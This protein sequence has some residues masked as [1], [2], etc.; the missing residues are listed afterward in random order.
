[1]IMWWFAIQLLLLL[2]AHSVIVKAQEEVDEIGIVAVARNDPICAKLNQKYYDCSCDVTCENYFKP[3]P[4][5]ADCHSGCFCNENFALSA[6]ICIR[7]EHCPEFNKQCPQNEHF[8][9][10]GCDLTCSV[11]NIY[12]I[13]C[14]PRCY[15][16]K[17]FVRNLITNTCIRKVE[18]S[19]DTNE[20]FL[21]SVDKNTNTIRYCPKDNCEQA[22]PKGKICVNTCPGCFCRHGYSRDVKTGKC[23]TDSC[24]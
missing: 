21:P 6:N 1:M 2:T 7:V 8:E 11:V 12:C 14:T 10:C 22:C 20:L 4:L 17:G 3:K 19:C 18:C 9:P 13:G 24:T 16:D 23:V 5:C 15:C